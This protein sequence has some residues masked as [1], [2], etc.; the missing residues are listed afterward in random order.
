MPSNEQIVQRFVKAG[1]RK[2][3]DIED[4]KSFIKKRRTYMDLDDET[5]DSLHYS[6]RENGDMENDEPGQEDLRH[7]KELGRAIHREFGHHVEVDM[8]YAD[9]WTFL[10]ITLR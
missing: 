7:A 1:S 10:N 8:D 4:V 3:T 5:K 9:E 2:A 6:T